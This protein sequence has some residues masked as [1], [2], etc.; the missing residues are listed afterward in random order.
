[1]DSLQRLPDTLSVL[2]PRSYIV[3][4]CYAPFYFQGLF[5]LGKM[6]GSYLQ[7]EMIIKRSEWHVEAIYILLYSK[8]T[9]L[10]IITE[11]S[12]LLA[13]LFFFVVLL[14]CV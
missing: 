10:G 2:S 6:L 12:L 7:S 1:M 14:I 9:H 3:F 4:V 8:R 11:E 13:F 5:I